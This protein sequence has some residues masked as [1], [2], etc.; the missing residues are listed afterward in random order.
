MAIRDAARAMFGLSGDVIRQLI[1]ALV[2]TSTETETLLVKMPEILRDLAITTVQTEERCQGEVRGPILWSETM[3]ARAGTA[4]A[5]DVFI[6]L[7]ARRAY[8]TP[9]NRVLVAALDAIRRAAMDA[10]PVA[11]QAYDDEVLSRAR[12][13]G[14]EAR[15]FLEHRT[16]RDVTRKRPS[17]R[18]FAKAAAGRRNRQYGPAIDV[19]DRV[20]NPLGLNHLLP[21]TDARTAWQHWVIVTLVAQLRIRGASPGAFRV[22]PG[23]DL[24]AGRLTYR[25]PNVARDTKNPLH[26]V[27]FERLLVDVPDPLGTSDL[28]EAEAALGRRSHGR[29]PV[30]VTGIADI[31]RAADL[32]FSALA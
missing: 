29:I 5:T 4:G 27:M 17:K 25:H 19:L 13:N 30:L 6:C 7:T 22:T 15:R 28:G 32:A 11:R 24:R 12:A 8:D 1:G 2:A 3:A 10:D 9:Q 21:F 14:D 18:D 20:R 31:E 23:G 16:M 26:G